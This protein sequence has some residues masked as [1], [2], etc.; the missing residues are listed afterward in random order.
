MNSAKVNEMSSKYKG[1]A[2]EIRALDAFT[3][4]SRAMSSIKTR[5]DSYQAGGDLTGTQFGVLEMLYHLGAL[6]QSDVGKK[7]LVS[8]SNVVAVIDKLE[9]LGLVKRERSVEDRRYIFVHLTPEGQD[10]IEALLPNHVAAIVATMSYLDAEE[11]VEF[12]RLCRKLGLG[13]RG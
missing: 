7:L 13:D 8:K 1:T 12:A 10:C 5:M 11:Q 4:F 9:A 2:E 6:H 3:K